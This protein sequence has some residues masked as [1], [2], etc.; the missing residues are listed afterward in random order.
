MQICEVFGR[1]GPMEEVLAITTCFLSIRSL[2]AR[3]EQYQQAQESYQSKY[4]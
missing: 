4:L 3:I 2:N 1:I